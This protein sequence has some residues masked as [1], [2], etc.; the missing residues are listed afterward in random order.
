MGFVEFSAFRARIGSPCYCA[1]NCYTPPL[2]KAT[3][4]K[5][6]HIL[7]F[8]KCSSFVVGFLRLE[9]SLYSYLAYLLCKPTEAYL[10][11]VGAMSLSSGYLTPKQRLIWGLKSKGLPEASI[12]REL[13]V[14]RQTVHKA[15][16]TA[17]SRICESLEEA[18]KL[19]KIEIETVN[20][21]KGFLVGYS[22]HFKTQAFVT[23]SAKNGVQIWYK[24]EGN[25][26]KCKKLQTCR[27]ML[28][29]EAKERNFL[30]PFDTSQTSPS[31]LAD[32]LF[33]RIAGGD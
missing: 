16:S 19:N 26:E 30:L 17:N 12:A 4:Q 2:Y 6:K 8:W 22:S 29:T 13:N 3:I 15:V 23:F 5:K 31:K 28:V 14:T 32:I 24:H 25:C 10:D 27:E 11:W 1:R 20:A 21:A 18:A 9:Q 7:F 33:S